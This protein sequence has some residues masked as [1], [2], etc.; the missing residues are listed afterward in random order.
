MIKK[1]SIWE[2]VKDLESK[3]SDKEKE[4]GEARATMLI[5]WGEEGKSIKGLCSASDSIAQMVFKVF[6][7]YHKTI[8]DL[9]KN[10]IKEE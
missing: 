10:K 6:S 1:V 3:M 7:Y 5:N 9:K 2:I 8:L 4:L